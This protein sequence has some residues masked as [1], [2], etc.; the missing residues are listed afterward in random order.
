VTGYF[1]DQIIAQWSNTVLLMSINILKRWQKQ[2]LGY[3]IL[4]SKD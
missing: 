4:N 1:S 2:V 3:R